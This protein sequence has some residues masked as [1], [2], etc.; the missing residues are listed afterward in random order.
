M[1]VLSSSYLARIALVF[2]ITT[3][4]V[5]KGQDSN[6]TA[7]SSNGIVNLPAYYQNTVWPGYACTNRLSKHDAVVDTEIMP[8]QLQFTAGGDTS[9][10]GFRASSPM[11]NNQGTLV[12]AATGAFPGT[13]APSAVEAYNRDGTLAWRFLNLV[14]ARRGFYASP[15]SFLA[16]QL[17]IGSTD[18]YLYALDQS[19]GNRNVQIQLEGAVSTAVAV[20]TFSNAAYVVSVVDAGDSSDFGFGTAAFLNLVDRRLF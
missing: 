1:T 10:R 8:Y 16:S 15:V 2:T 18:G 11:L 4:Y 9:Q 5:V 3:C 12:I 14:T 20:S 17:L 6:E 19:S 13:G 7:L